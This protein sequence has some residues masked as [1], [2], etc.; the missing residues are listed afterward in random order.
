M[1]TRETETDPQGW[2]E[3]GT[4]SCCLVGAETQLGEMTVSWR[5]TA[6][7]PAQHCEWISCH[8]IVQLQ[9]AKI[10]IFTL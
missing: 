6:E 7:V 4:G 8:T 9:L 1:L 10:V 2:R 3:R 5:W